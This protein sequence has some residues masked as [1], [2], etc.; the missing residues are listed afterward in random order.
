MSFYL[1]DTNVCIALDPTDL[2]LCPI[3]L[4]ELY[5]GAFRSI[6]PSRHLTL[7][8]KLIALVRYA[9]YDHAAAEAYG[10]LRAHLSAQGT[11]IGPHD[12]QIASIA[13]ALRMVVVTH[14]VAE[15]SRVPGL[16]VED[17]Q[18]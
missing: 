16:I 18:T 14:N 11:P 8:G 12:M 15:F 4:G 5:Y 6:N 13:V 1:L 7:L 9:P 3:V 10:R 17:W 2:F